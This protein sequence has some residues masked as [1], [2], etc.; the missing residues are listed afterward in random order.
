MEPHRTRMQVRTLVLDSVTRP[1]AVRVFLARATVAVAAVFSVTVE[2]VLLVA[3]VETQAQLVMVE[4]AEL[5]SR[6][7]PEHQASQ[8][9]LVALAVPAEMQPP[10]KQVTVVPVVQ[11][12]SAIP[13]Q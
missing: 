2:M 13:A 6:E 11:A 7:R 3:Q 4:M 5:A 9:Q 1:I 12:V 10:E 8:V